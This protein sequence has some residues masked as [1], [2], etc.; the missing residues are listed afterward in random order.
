MFL[1]GLV[2]AL[3]GFVHL[4]VGQNATTSSNATYTNPVLDM[5]GAD[6]WVQST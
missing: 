4:V 5:V 1:K 6:P 2:I 3:A